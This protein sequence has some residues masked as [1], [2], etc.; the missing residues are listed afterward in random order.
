MPVR[1]EFGGSCAFAEDGGCV[2]ERLAF[3]PQAFV[4]LD[5]KLGRRSVANFGTRTDAHESLL[6]TGSGGMLAASRSPVA[7]IPRNTVA[8]RK[9]GTRSK[10]GVPSHKRTAGC[11]FHTAVHR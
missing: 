6:G 1:L 3:T 2:S 10:R 8:N 4:V 7:T 9:E 11:S 5:S